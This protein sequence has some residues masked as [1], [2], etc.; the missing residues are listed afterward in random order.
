VDLT[1]IVHLIA[2][3]IWIGVVG[4]E[5]AIEFDGMKSDENLIKASKMH[6]TTDLWVEIPAF[7]T[8]LITGLLM[9]NESHLEGVFLYKV[10]FA[11]L[12][13]FFNIICV[14]AVFKRRKYALKSDIEGMKTTDKAMAIGGLI[15]PTFLI[16]FGLAIYIAW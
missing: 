14:Y 16:A 4:A 3:G 5:F 10:I 7:T 1:L 15:V 6:Y 9:L 8:V 2:L 12:A 11:L 13:I